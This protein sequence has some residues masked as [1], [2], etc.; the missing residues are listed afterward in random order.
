MSPVLTRRLD[1]PSSN[2]RFLIICDHAS[3]FVP[4][5]L[6]ALGLPPEEL[7]RHIAYDI[8][9]LGVPACGFAVFAPFDRPQSR[10]R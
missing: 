3:N 8:G 6:N 1:A 5:E 10:S 7:N 2:R 9:A 4:P